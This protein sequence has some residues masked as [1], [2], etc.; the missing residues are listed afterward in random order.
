MRCL[1]CG[2]DLPLLKR[3]AG[4]EFCS[5]AHRREY[6][7]EYSDLAL[8]RLLQ[9][10]PPGP[11]NSAGLNGAPNL[12]TPAAN[13]YP[14]AAPGVTMP[15]VQKVE[16]LVATTKPVVAPPPTV[17]RKAETRPAIPMPSAP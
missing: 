17:A 9:S 7:Q 13:R 16:P 15:A 6:Q 8:G 2:K 12:F 3:M 4:S 1:Q 10:K 5:D 14:A 11:E